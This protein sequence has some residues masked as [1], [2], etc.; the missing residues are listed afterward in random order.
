MHK[1]KFHKS[2]LIIEL[3]VMQM[4]G[5]NE[6]NYT[7]LRNLTEFEVAYDLSRSYLT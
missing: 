2:L 7:H 6:E 5:G 1:M 3:D 4:Q